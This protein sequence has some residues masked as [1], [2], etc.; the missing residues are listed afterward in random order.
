MAGVTGWHRLS[1]KKKKAESI[2]VELFV[3]G[4]EGMGLGDTGITAKTA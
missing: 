2:K 3:S 1:R 4:K